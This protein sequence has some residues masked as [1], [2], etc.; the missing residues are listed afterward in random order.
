MNCAGRVFHG[1]ARV[2]HATYTSAR[3]SG[4]LDSHA[5]CRGLHVLR[6]EVRRIRGDAVKPLRRSDAVVE[7]EVGR[8]PALGLGDRAVGVEVDL[9]V[10][11][12]LGSSSITYRP[13][14][15]SGTTSHLQN[16]SAGEMR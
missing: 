15:F 4:K 14:Q 1:G 10:L 12:S 13:V 11:A 2:A 6:A 16:L 9:F 3:R 5:L 7:V 8:D